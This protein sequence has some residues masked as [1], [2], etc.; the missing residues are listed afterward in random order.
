MLRLGGFGGWGLNR[1]LWVAGGGLFRWWVLGISFS[2]C[3][4]LLVGVSV[5]G[6]LGW[7]E[8]VDG[9]VVVT[10]CVWLHERLWWQWVFEICCRWWVFG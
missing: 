9:E 8:S 2:G 1:W 3:G 5:V 10:I 6:I 4:L 7:V